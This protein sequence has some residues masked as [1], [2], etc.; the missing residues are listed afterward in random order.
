MSPKTVNNEVS[1]KSVPKQT[2][3]QNLNNL[4][5][6]PESWNKKSMIQAKFHR[7]DDSLF[8][9][10]KMT[11]WKKE[12]P[13]LLSDSCG[14]KEKK[15]S[16]SNGFE[17]DNSSL[18]AGKNPRLE[19]QRPNSVCLEHVDDEDTEEEQ[20]EVDNKVCEAPKQESEHLCLNRHEENVRAAFHSSTKV[21]YIRMIQSQ[22]YF[23]RGIKV[24]TKR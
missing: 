2:V 16:F 9:E 3:C 12:T 18:S 4:Q 21:S 13:R 11:N 8:A 19:S 15:S 17:S 23:L 5:D 22:R 6:K 7:N 10:S 1:C 24:R 20:C 14:L